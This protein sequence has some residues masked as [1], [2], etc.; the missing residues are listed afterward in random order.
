MRGVVHV[1]PDLGRLLARRD[2]SPHTIGEHLGAS[3]RERAEAGGLQLAQD[4][5]VREARQ[6]GHVVDLGGRVAL[7]V[8]VGQRLVQRG[9]RV[10]VEREVD[11][12]VL[13]VD[14]VDLGE[15]GDLA[16][17]EHVLDE[18]VARDRVRVLLLAR[19]RERAEL[20]LHA[21][22]VRLV[23]VEVLDEVDLVRA[24]ARAACEVGEGAELE[25][26]V[27][28]EDRHAVVEVE[29]FSGLDLLPD[30]LQRLQRENGDQLLLSMTARVSASS[31]S[32]RGAASR[33]DLASEA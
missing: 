5:L 15:A 18:L 20:A 23:H 17:A 4:L 12:R 25:E 8:H 6:R 16:L 19:G 2:E 11:V 24:S 27:G 26:V 13:A 10:A 3:A 21:A 31:S 32:R 22:D 1:E 28:L 14:H 7:E 29:T 30:R 33:Q 9:D